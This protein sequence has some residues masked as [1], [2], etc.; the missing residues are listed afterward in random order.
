MKITITGYASTIHLDKQGHIILPS[1]WQSINNKHPIPL[2]YEHDP[3]Y[4]MGHVTHHITTPLGLLITAEI[5]CT[6]QIIKMI[7]SRQAYFSVG[8][9]APNPANRYITHAQL[10][11]ISLVCKPANPHCRVSIKG[12]P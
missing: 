9:L 8:I 7:Q 11:E 1:V 5:H 12:K 4:I 6:D 2:L 10:H 3:R